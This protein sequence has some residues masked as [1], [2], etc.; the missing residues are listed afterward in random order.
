MKTAVMMCGEI[1]DGVRQFEHLKKF[2]IDGI[3]PDI[4]IQTYKCEQ[5]DQ[6]IDLYQ[7]K[8]FIIEDQNDVA[9]EIET[10]SSVYTHNIDGSCTKRRFLSMLRNR[11]LV[12]SLLDETY[13]RV[14]ISRLDCYGTQSIATTFY[15]TDL[16]IPR[17]GDY[18][19]ILD[20]CAWGSH[21]DI[22]YYCSLADNVERYWR[23]GVTLHPETM[24]SY[25]L[26]SNKDIQIAR[27][28]M[29]LFL[30]DDHFNKY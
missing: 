13:D 30:R 9:E 2:F 17:G 8:K 23:N 5:S 12:S 7:P 14:L 3:C 11:K 21:K 19:G 26:R 1:R 25:H 28:D 29:A 4:Y 16:C 24:L 6:I 20:L 18:G 10:I 15:T 27:V 22:M